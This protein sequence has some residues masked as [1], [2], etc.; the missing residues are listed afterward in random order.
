MASAG[1]IDVRHSVPAP[2]QYAAVKDVFV[3]AFTDA[4]GEA[5]GQVIGDLVQQLLHDVSAEDLRDFVTTEGERVM[6]A[7]LFSRLQLPDQRPG[8]L[9]SPMA[10]STPVQGQGIGQDLIRF[11]LDAL[12]NQGVELVLT[13]GDPGFYGRTG[14]QALDPETLPPPH[15]LSQ[16]IGWLGQALNER[17][18]PVYTQ[19]I[20]CV[21]AF[22]DPALW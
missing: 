22:D 15:R 16:P 17:A 5:E 18:L 8:F 19:P 9:L 3:Q 11:G 14:F 20:A 10:V 4:E 13:Y 7:V 2:R 6:A 12:K 21:S 1:S